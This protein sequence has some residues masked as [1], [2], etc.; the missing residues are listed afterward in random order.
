MSRMRFALIG[1]GEIS[2]NNAAGIVASRNGELSAVMD[3]NPQAARSLAE[4]FDVRHTTELESILSDDSVDAVVVAVPHFLHADV[5]CKAAEAG[6][7]VI[8]EKPLATNLDDAD[9]MIESCRKMGVALSVLFSFRYEPRLVRAR[10]LIQ[11]GAIG[12]IIATNIQF[13]TEKPASYYVEG[14]KKRVQTDWRGSWSTAGG[15]VLLMNVCH[16]LDYFRYVTGLEAVR[17]SAEMSSDNSPVEVEDTISVAMRYDTGAIGSVQASAVAR[18]EH[19]R[20]DER[21][22]GTHGSLELAPNTRVYTMRKA[23]G[24][25]PARWQRVKH[26]PKTNRIATYFDRFIAAI[27]S[28]DTPEVTGADGR[29]NLALVLAAYE[30]ATSGASVVLGEG[31]R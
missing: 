30:A 2:P 23:G 28:G 24:L 5:S 4:Q 11:A 26:E 10:E 6:K 18:G 16:M 8:V 19:W 3:L 29:M 14:Y 31:S 7:H 22:W 17:V 20:S 13:V 27:D 9:L 15:G 21:I 1:C 25:K 12:E